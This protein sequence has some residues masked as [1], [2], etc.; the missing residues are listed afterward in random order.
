[1]IWRK[2]TM[3]RMFLVAICT[4]ALCISSNVSAQIYPS[5][6]VTIIVPFAAGG[7]ADALARLLG[8]RMRSTL[9]QPMIVESV[10]GAS[11]TTGVSRVVRAAPDG[12]TIGIG[13]W[14]T[15]VLN[16]AFYNLP[17]DL[18][19]DLEPITLLPANP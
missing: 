3:K 1:M 11:G 18:L 15:H 8:A 7:P 19:T 12:Y 14:S 10:V 4:A 5:K 6:P 16:G 13:H 2:T 9:G 17:Y